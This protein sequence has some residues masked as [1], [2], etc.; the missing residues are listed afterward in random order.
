MFTLVVNPDGSFL[1]TLQGPLDHPRQDGDDS[2]TLGDTGLRL[3]FSGLLI[4]IDGDGDAVV[5]G[6]AAGS[7]VI[8]VEDDVPVQA[9]QDGDCLLYTSRCV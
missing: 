5:G 1:F 6:F 2:E 3:D 7:F 9:G 4:A 8:D